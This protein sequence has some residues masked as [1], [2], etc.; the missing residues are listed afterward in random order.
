MTFWGRKKKDIFTVK[1]YIWVC[2]RYLLANYLLNHLNNMFTRFR[3][4]W[5]YLSAI[6]PQNFPFFSLL[7]LTTAIR[8]Q[9]GSI[10]NFVINYHSYSGSDRHLSMVRGSNL[11]KALKYRIHFEVPAGGSWTLC[12]DRNSAGPSPALHQAPVS[13]I[14]HCSAHRGSSWEKSSTLAIAFKRIIW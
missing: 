8:I 5:E 3:I 7:H 2:S 6:N 11:Q 4:S 14:L 10:F 13:I 9:K 12:Q 1:H